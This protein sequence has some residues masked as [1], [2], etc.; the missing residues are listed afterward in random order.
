[1]KGIKQL[2]SRLVGNENTLSN[3]VLFID[4][5]GS[6][7]K[8]QFLGQLWYWTGKAK[9]TNGWIAKTYDQWYE[10]IRVKEQTLRRASKQFKEM[11]FLETKFKKFNGIPTLHYRVD[12]DRLIE[13]LLSFCNPQPLQNDSLGNDNLEASLE[14]DNLEASTN[15][16]YQRL[17]TK[18]EGSEATKKIKNQSLLKLK[19]QFVEFHKKYKGEKRSFET[20]LKEL[21]HNFPDEWKD[22]VPIL[23]KALEGQIRNKNYL[24]MHKGFAPE[25]KSLRNWIIQRC[26]EIE[27]PEKEEVKQSAGFSLAPEIAN[28]LNQ[29][30]K[31][32]ENAA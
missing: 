22:I 5:T 29:A 11:G 9:K 17:H 23:G 8:G 24:K 19:N 14:G 32:R 6:H 20:E 4:F 31:A 26:W 12:E 13:K 28:Q 2:L 25:W 16:D 15:R 1:M 7:E 10:E 18:R 30:R 3:N 27:I 21:K